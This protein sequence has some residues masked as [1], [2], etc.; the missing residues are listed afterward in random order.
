MTAES[1]PMSAATALAGC[2]V[3]MLLN[4]CGATFCWPLGPP[5]WVSQR[6]S[7]PPRVLRRKMPDGRPPKP[8]PPPQAMY[9]IIYL[10][11][12]A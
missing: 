3:N 8:T 10:L 6:K 9:T 2:I 7:F 1:S 11:W 12:V 4:H 5:V